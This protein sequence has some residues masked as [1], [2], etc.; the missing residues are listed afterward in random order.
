MEYKDFIENKIII[1]EKNRSMNGNA[2]WTKLQ[3]NSY[4]TDKR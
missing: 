1:A 4:C 2:E 3:A